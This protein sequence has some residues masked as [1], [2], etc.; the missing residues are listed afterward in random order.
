MGHHHHHHH[1]HHHHHATGN[2]KFAFFL[3]LGF[4][5]LELVGGF[6]VN[7]VAIMSDALHDFGDSLAL[8][9][10]YFLQRKSE[11]EGNARYTYGYKR[12]SVAGALL[13]SLILI[14]GAGFIVAEAV[15]RL[16]DPAM[17][18]PLGMLAFAILGIAVNGAAFFKLQG[19]F[20]LNQK[21]VSLHMLEDLLGWVAVLIV[22][23]VLLFFELPWLD[24]LLSV[25]ISLFMLV[26]AL[27][28]AF[29]AL[30]VLLQ[31]NPLADRLE[32]V[33]AQLLAL[34]PVL[35][36]HQLRVWSLDGEHHV[37]SA[38][39]VVAAVG[40]PDA[41]ATLKNEI[42]NAL[43]PF[44]ITEVTLELEQ[45]EERCALQVQVYL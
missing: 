3:N 1:G 8:G 33:R 16:L 41:A 34:Q 2:I 42:R 5:V 28:N 6:F 15:E 30:K 29:A 24:P 25:G 21:A 4:A 17:P 12:Y 26:H 39:V 13:T 27:R 22:S 38:H 32:Q 31:A 14:V 11:Q 9:M 44:S 45:A 7:S 19:G 20:N 23:V 40:E 35:G 18:E 10:A 43:K 36:V 37:L